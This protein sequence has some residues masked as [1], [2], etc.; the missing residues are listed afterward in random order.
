MCPLGMSNC[1]VP[2]EGGPGRTWSCWDLAKKSPLE[3]LRDTSHGKYMKNCQWQQITSS[4]LQSP[5]LIDPLVLGRCL[6][7]HFP[8]FFKSWIGLGLNIRSGSFGD[9]LSC[10]VTS[11]HIPGGWVL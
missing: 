5:V 9:N 10:C 4:F 11:I 6:A 8:H 3:M 2:T 1:E 7:R